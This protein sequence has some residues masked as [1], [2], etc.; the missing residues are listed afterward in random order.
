MHFPAVV[1]RELGP[2]PDAI[3]RAKDHGQVTGARNDRVITSPLLAVGCTATRR[4]L[5]L[6]GDA[7][8]ASAYQGSPDNSV[9]ARFARLRLGVTADDQL[10]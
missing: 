2:H 10:P 7:T 8:W 4:I 9:A 6:P 5:P 1:L 3:K